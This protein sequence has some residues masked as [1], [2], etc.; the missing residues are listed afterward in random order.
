MGISKH[1]TCA[2]G[3]SANCFQIL[4]ARFSNDVAFR[5]SITAATMQRKVFS[6]SAD[7]PIGRS[8]AVR[9]TGGKRVMQR[10]A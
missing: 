6:E 1:E 7:W 4:V 9:V 8:A 2:K 3:E 10:K 5:F